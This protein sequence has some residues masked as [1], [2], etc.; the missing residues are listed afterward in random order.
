MIHIFATGKLKKVHT[1]QHP[2]FGTFF[3]LILDARAKKWNPNTE[4]METV[5]VH[6]ALKLGKKTAEEAL[7]VPEGALV[8]VHGNATSREHEGRWYTEA[9]ANQI[10][11]V[12]QATPQARPQPAREPGADDDLAF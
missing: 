11:V 7:K 4:T 2:D 9:W 8:E 12:E 1:Q 10:V 5:G 3:T 6:L